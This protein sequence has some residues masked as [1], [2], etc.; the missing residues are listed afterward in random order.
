VNQAIETMNSLAGKNHPLSGAVFEH[1]KLTLRFSGFEDTVNRAITQTGGVILNEADI[2]W[3]DVRELKHEFFD[4]QQP[5]WRISVPSTVGA[6]P[7]KGDFFYDWGGAQRWFIAAPDQPCDASEVFAVA[8][9]AGG[10][11]RLFKNGDR[12]AEIFQPLPGPILAIH[13]RLKQ[14]FDP[15]ALFNPGRMYAQ[16]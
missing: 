13:Q 6:L 4:T 1:G 2:F 11:A 10:H 5:L 7:L 8:A 12:Q 15:F 3:H 16:L 9:K 14:S